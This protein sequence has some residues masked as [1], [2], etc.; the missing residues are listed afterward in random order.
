MSATDAP[1]ENWRQFQGTELGG[2]MNQLYGSNKPKIDYPKPKQKKFQPAGNF[3]GLGS[4]AGADDVRKHTIIKAP[5]IDVP[6]VG[7]G[8]GRRKK[9]AAVDFIPKKRGESDMRREIEDI[10]MRE[11]YYRPAVGPAYSSAE[12]KDKLSQI[13]QYKGGK[14]LPEE[15]TQVAGEAPFEVIQ[16]KKEKERIQNVRNAKL[17]ASGKYKPPSD[18]KSIPKLSIEEELLEQISS[19]IQ[20]RN[21]YLTELMADSSGPM[22]AKTQTIISR[23]KGEISERVR[24]LRQLEGGGGGG[25]R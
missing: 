25:G 10:K 9:F 21:E 24:Q 11:T 5:P 12:E 18:V 17:I 2:L 1:A 15:L 20:E 19:E 22:N 4:K 14:G 3:I 16:R 13:N 7:T 8:S 23:V 6:I